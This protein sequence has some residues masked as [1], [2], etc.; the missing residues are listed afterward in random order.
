[1]H[2]SLGKK[3]FRLPADE[4]FRLGTHAYDNDCLNSTPPF[5]RG[6]SNRKEGDREFWRR[7]G[8]SNP[9]YRFWP[10]QRFSKLKSP[11]ACC[12]GINNLAR[13]VSLFF[14][15]KTSCSGTIVPQT[16]PQ[17]RSLF[18]KCADGCNVMNLIALA[19]GVVP[20]GSSAGSIGLNQGT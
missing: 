6:G 7:G 9:R 14:G 17:R 8:D 15:S 12:S 2:T 10:V 19:L 4:N 13:P 11:G 5:V 20:G 18:V 16:V 1:M 3:E